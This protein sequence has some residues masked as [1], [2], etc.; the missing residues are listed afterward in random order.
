MILHNALPSQ[1]A[2]SRP[3]G[4][5]WIAA[6]CLAMAAFNLAFSVLAWRG[7][8]A[9]ARGAPLLGGG[10]EIHGPVVF[11]IVAFL[12]ARAGAGL[13]RMSRWSR[14][15]TI[16]LSALGVYLSVPGLSSAVV[17]VRPGGLAAS[18]LQIIARVAVI[19][20]LLQ[21]QVKDAFR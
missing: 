13:L 15:L 19:W 12:Y 17:D 2:K 7:A 20:Y 18:G 8:V 3:S 9:L 4:V 14:H 1:S 6:L 16:L 21:P 11:L 10:L 5:T